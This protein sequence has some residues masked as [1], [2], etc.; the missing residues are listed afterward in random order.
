MLLFSVLVFYKVAVI[1]QYFTQ[2]ETG[3]T[4]QSEGIKNPRLKYILYWNEAY[5]NKGEYDTRKIEK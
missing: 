5:K 2:L 1:L 4:F 3:F